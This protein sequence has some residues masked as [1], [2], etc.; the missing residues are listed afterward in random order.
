[1]QCLKQ[2]DIQVQK[3][4]PVCNH[5]PKAMERQKSETTVLK[6]NQNLDCKKNMIIDERAN[7]VGK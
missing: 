5:Y 3:L 1:M 7:P 4:S 6:R 2:C